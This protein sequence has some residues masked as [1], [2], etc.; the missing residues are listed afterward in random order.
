MKYF[1]EEELCA[2]GDRHTFSAVAE[3]CYNWSCGQGWFQFNKDEK[4]PGGKKVLNRD[5]SA[6]IKP[7]SSNSLISERKLKSYNDK[8]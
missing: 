6:S 7:K 3:Y 2:R 4:L 1:K 8:K 5:G